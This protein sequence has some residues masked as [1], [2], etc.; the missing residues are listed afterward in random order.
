MSCQGLMRLWLM[1]SKHENI[2]VFSFAGENCVR[3]HKIF[4]WSSVFGRHER[5]WICLHGW[6]FFLALTS[7]VGVDPEF[8]WEERQT[9]EDLKLWC[10]KIDQSETINKNL[11]GLD[12]LQYSCEGKQQNWKVWFHISNLYAISKC[13]EVH[14]GSRTSDKRRLLIANKFQANYSI[15]HLLTDQ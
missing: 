15:F 4:A 10:V 13:I 6:K 8:S 9:L 3:L 12:Q 14:E 5:P 11:R 1:G 2:F 7:E